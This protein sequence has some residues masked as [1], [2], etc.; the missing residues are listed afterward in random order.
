M[1]SWNCN[2]L[3]GGKLAALV[4][5]LDA[6][7]SSPHAVALQEVDG[8]VPE[9]AHERYW[10]SPDLGNTALAPRGG[11]GVALLLRQDVRLLGAI[12][13]VCFL[14]AALSIPGHGQMVVVAVY[15]PPVQRG[16]AARRY[17]EIWESALEAARRLQMRY[18]VPVDALALLGDFNA[19]L[20]DLRVGE[21]PESVA[22]EHRSEGYRGYMVT[23]LRYSEC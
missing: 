17:C 15:I 16:Y 10:T 21:L 13:D 22:R 12:P 14:A 23:P 8:P 1:A 3:G 18:S 4:S 11:R 9:R 2:G 19:H 20:G 7:G 5:T 6:A